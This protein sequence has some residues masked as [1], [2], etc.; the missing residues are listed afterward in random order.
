MQATKTA[1]KK[2]YN[3]QFIAILDTAWKL[4]TSG[5]ILVIPQGNM[6]QNNPAEV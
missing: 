4:W 3:K 2:L 1:N 5:M 6:V